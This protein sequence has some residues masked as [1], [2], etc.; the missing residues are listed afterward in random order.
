MSLR[1][2]PYVDNALSR[3]GAS[4]IFRHILR[5][6]RFRDVRGSHALVDHALIMT[7]LWKDR[8]GK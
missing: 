1:D 8:E 5:I 4:E 7:F 2:H 6:A 3:L